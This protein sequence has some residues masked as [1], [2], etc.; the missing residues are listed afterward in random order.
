VRVRGGIGELRRDFGRCGV[1][2]SEETRGVSSEESTAEGQDE[3]GSRRNWMRAGVLGVNDG[4]VSI[5]GRARKEHNDKDQINATTA[6]PSP[7]ERPRLVTTGGGEAPARG[8]GGPRMSR[9]RPTCRCK[10][11]PALCAR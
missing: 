5:A 9:G 10:K 1:A 4:L 11:E 6:A 8:P 2:G 3:L 7:R